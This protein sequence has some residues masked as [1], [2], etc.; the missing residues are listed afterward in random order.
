MQTPVQHSTAAP[1]FAPRRLGHVNL[2]VDDLASSETFYSEV[3]GLTVEFTEP[4]LIA[5]FLGTGHTPHD[6]GMI[7]KTNGVARYGRNGLLQLP[8]TIG[9]K[10]GLNHMAWE[11]ENE[12]TL[13]TGYRRLKEAGIPTDITV[14]HQVAH[15]VYMFDPDGNSNEFYCD[16]LK[17]WRSV[18]HG[19]MEL[20]TSEWDPLTAEGFL[21]GRYDTAPV[22]RTHRSAPVR[23]RRIT[24]AVLQTTQL[25]TMCEFYTVIGGLRVVSDEGGVVYLGGSLDDYE[26]SLVLVAGD[27]SQYHHASFELSGE[28]VLSAAEIA[29]ASKGIPIAKRVDAPWK[30]SIYLRDPDGLMTEWFVRRAA[31]RNLREHAG[32]ALIDVV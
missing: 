23:P 19:A 8:G 7:Q 30:R 5:T 31:P 29:L 21:E 16:T 32:Q 2:W 4:D 27:A 18:L 9:L 26:F 28:A 20:I 6:L 17:N 15:S 25:K 12:A 14:D 3:C 24:H 11:L 1:Y 13:V 10:A 22:L